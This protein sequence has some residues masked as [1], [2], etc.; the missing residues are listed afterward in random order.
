VRRYELG[1]AAIYGKN[2]WR[3][4]ERENNYL[5]ARTKRLKR[6]KTETGKNWLRSKEDET[7]L[8]E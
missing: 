8:Y 2:H 3:V 4:N 1:A 7:G 5:R 6:K